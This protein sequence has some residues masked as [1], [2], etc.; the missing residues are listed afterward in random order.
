M[1]RIE[2]LLAAGTVREAAEAYAGPLLPSSEAPGVVA[3]A[4]G[5][6]PGCARP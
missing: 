1:R 3:S 6:T 2:G 5:W 4:S